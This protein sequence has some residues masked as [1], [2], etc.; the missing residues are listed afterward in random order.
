MPARRSRTLGRIRLCL[1][2]IARAAVSLQ[3]ARGPGRAFE[4]LIMAELGRELERV[5]FRVWLQLSNGQRVGSR[6]P[7]KRFV[8]RAGR[9]GPLPS[10]SAG[11]NGPSVLCFQR[12]GAPTHWEIWNGIEFFGRS[13]GTHEIDLAIVPAAVA[14]DIRNSPRGG[15]PLGHGW[16]SLECK[17]VAMPGGLDELRSF[18]ARMY[19]TTLLQS[20]GRYL[21]LA[22]PVPRIASLAS[23]SVGRGRAPLIY[24]QENRT[25]FAA[26]ARTGRFS[27]GTASMAGLYNVRRYDDL[28][29]GGKLDSFI[30]DLA[31][32]ISTRLPDNP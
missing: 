31:R 7:T 2:A 26:V 19:D 11:P 18:I 29:N 13:R 15:S 9:P 30:A 20:H 1:S 25:V 8:Q 14:S 16:V 5:G 12:D 21:G 24:Y 6:S 23:V 3:H 27:A 32:W 10:A 4:L 17:H 28:M 22:P